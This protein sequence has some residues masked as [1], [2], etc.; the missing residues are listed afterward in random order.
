MEI[1]RSKLAAVKYKERAIF[2]EAKL[3]ET[4]SMEQ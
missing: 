4:Q 3:V 1:F 2:L